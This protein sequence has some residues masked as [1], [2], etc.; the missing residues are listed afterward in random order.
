M[1]VLSEIKTRS[2]GVEANAIESFCSSEFDAAENASVSF[3]KNTSYIAFEDRFKRTG[4]Y[5]TFAVRTL[6]KNSLVVFN[7]GSASK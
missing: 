2:K 4:G 7:S 1:D 3:L 6:S 5:I